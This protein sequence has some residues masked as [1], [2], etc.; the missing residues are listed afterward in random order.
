VLDDVMFCSEAILM[1]PESSLGGRRSF[2]CQKSHWYFW[3]LRR[4][5]LLP[6]MARHFA[7]R[8]L[9]WFAAVGDNGQSYQPT[10]WHSTMRGICRMKRISEILSN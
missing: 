10:T 2:L 4:I 3:K 8:S 9:L 1:S 6:T 7:C 5:I